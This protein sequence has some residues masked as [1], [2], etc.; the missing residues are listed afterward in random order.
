[1]QFRFLRPLLAPLLS[2]AFL[3]APLASWANFEEGEKAYEQGDY[4]PAFRAFVPLAKEGHVP[5]QAMLGKVYFFGNGAPLDGRA[6]ADWYQRAASKGHATAQF[7]LGRMYAAGIGVTKDAKRAAELMEQAANQ[8]LPWAMQALGGMY[9]QGSGVTKNEVQAY[10]WYSLAIAEPET[11]ASVDFIKL[12]K[13]AKAELDK[14]LSADNVSEAN[15]L[16]AEWRA[17]A[18]PVDPQWMRPVNL[19]NGARPVATNFDPNA[20]KRSREMTDGY[21][22]KE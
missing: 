6:S 13:A 2:I 12:A 15:K 18:K 8:R 22:P 4:F 9:L 5:S 3:A 19:P 20:S 14:T 16:A 11:P 7:E 17:K 1:M 10:K 21:F